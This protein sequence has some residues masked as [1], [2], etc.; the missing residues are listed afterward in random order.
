M[1]QQRCET[2]D[3]E[4]TGGPRAQCFEVRAEG[5]LEPRGKAWCEIVV[6]HAR[7]LRSAA[8]G[9]CRIRP[10]S[11]RIRAGSFTTRSSFQS[12]RDFYRICLPCGPEQ[13]GDGLEDRGLINT[14]LAS[15]GV[16]IDEHQTCS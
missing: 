5:L 13:A 7:I 9:L 3:L 6:G 8:T 14:T 11:K 12:Y 16:L 2:A 15:F 10:T 4:C 1:H